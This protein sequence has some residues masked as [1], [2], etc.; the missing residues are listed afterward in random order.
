MYLSHSGT[1]AQI[2]QSP[3]LTVEEAAQRARCGVKTIYTA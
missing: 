1:L 3:W 2:E